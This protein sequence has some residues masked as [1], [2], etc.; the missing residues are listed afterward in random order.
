MSAAG[1]FEFLAQF[2]TLRT[3]SKQREILFSASKHRFT[4]S[5]PN[6]MDA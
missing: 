6:R 4:P 1:Q 3:T 5:L 2:S